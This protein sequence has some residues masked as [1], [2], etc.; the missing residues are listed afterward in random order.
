MGAIPKTTGLA[1]GHDHDIDV[2]QKLKK[3]NQMYN[4]CKS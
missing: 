3:D 4:E 2:P 1:T